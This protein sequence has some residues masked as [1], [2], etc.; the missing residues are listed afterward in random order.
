MQIRIS[1]RTKEIIRLEAA[2]QSTR[3]STV[4]SMGEVIAQYAEKLNK[5]HRLLLGFIPESAEYWANHKMDCNSD[6]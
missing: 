4:V 3:P 6:D 5:K 2:R 1:P